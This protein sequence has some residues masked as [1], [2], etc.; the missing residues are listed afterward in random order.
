MRVS[1]DGI[2]IATLIKDAGLA[3]SNSEALRLLKQGAVRVDGERV[4]NREQ[5]FKSGDSLV[6][7]V[8]KRRFARVILE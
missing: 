7:Q 3:T 6:F 2:L 4:H 1:G 5:L 8:G